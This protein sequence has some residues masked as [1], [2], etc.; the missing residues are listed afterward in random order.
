[1]LA[2]FLVQVRQGSII[3]DLAESE[4]TYLAKQNKELRRL[5][6]ECRKELYEVRQTPFAFQV[7]SCNS[8]WQACLAAL[9]LNP[10]PPV[11]PR[12]QPSNLV[13][14]LALLPLF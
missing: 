14:S 4:P 2:T 3:D 5:L 11:R 1:M 10:A 13:F 8:Y 6:V 9:P 7:L 12:V